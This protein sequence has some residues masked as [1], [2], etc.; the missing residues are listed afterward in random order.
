MIKLFRK[1][2]KATECLMGA[3]AIVQLIEAE[4]RR[5]AIV[6]EI[7]AETARKIFED[8]KARSMYDFPSMYYTI[9]RMALDELE[10]KYTEG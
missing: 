5:K 3:S 7:E 2:A 10:K 8:I 9:S 1:K 6:K 4:E